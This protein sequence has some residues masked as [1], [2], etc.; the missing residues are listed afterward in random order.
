MNATVKIDGTRIIILFGVTKNSIEWIILELVFEYRD[1]FKE[2][3]LLEVWNEIQS[4]PIEP[5]A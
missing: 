2:I 3:E 5:F 4:E 1:N